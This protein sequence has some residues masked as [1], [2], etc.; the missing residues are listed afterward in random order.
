M[1]TIFQVVCSNFLIMNNVSDKKN[2]K[3]KITMKKFQNLT[4]SDFSGVNAKKFEEWKMEVLKTRTYIYIVMVIYLILNIKSFGYTGSV[5]Y[6]TPLVFLTG[7]ILIVEHTRFSTNK[8]ITYAIISLFFLI[9]LNI[10]LFLTT[11]RY[12]GES[13]I[14]IVVLTWLLSRYQKNNRNA[15]VIG[16][17]STVLKRALSQ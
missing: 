10:I 8:Q 1:C 13:L 3:E 17:D 2:C 4:I 14:V 16:I 12:I 9:L 5:L 7:I 15:F 11:G 6:D